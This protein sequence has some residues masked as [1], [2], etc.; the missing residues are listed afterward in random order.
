M[1]SLFT[2]VTVV[3]GA[4][5]ISLGIKVKLSIETVAACSTAKVGMAKRSSEAKAKP[6]NGG[7]NF[8]DF[9]I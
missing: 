1:S 9:S 3:P 5:L 2:Q 7:R 4:I 8:K 6:A